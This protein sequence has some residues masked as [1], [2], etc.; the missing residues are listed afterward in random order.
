MTLGTPT[1]VNRQSAARLGTPRLRPQA[2]RRE[3]MVIAADYPV[4]DI[5]WTM[6]REPP[7]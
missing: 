3:D 2:D 4:L 7:G 5:F 6:T 1:P